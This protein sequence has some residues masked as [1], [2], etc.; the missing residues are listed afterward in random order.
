MAERNF[1]TIKDC[2]PDEDPGVTPMYSQF[3]MVQYGQGME[4]IDE[5]ININD[6]P[7]AQTELDQIDTVTVTSDGDSLPSLLS[8]VQENIDPNVQDFNED[9]F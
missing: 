4:T 2:A 8:Q 3:Y 9:L 1:K 5:E 6:V 7:S